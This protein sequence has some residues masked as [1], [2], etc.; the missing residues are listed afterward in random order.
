[1]GC[2][3][4]IS[5]N[6][7]GLIFLLVISVLS[8]CAHQKPRKPSGCLDT[9]AHHVFSG[10]QLLNQGQ[11]YGAGREFELALE[12]DPKCSPAYCGKG[13]VLGPKMDFEG[14]FEAL[15][16]AKKPARFNTP[17]NSKTR[18]SRRGMAATMANPFWKMLHG[19]SVITPMPVIT[20]T[21]TAGPVDPV[22][23]RRIKTASRA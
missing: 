14:A 13:L 20:K 7:W 21:T 19:P 2:F 4:K 17:V 8:G 10:T 6:I 22:T 16:M 9:P 15:A 18:W 23:V 11:L 5:I 12:L 1:M 3:K